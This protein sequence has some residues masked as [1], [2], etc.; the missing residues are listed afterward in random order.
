MK[1]IRQPIRE[2]TTRA[3]FAQPPAEVIADLNRRVRGWVQYFHFRNCTSDM[4]KLRRYLA[5]RVRNFLRRRRGR[6]PWVYAGY[7]DAILHGRYGLYRI[8]VYAPWTRAA[9]HAVR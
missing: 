9:V 2:R 6:R 1:R 3:H 4:N 5:D 8:P 7:T